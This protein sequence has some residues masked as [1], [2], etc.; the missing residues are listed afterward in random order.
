MIN[1]SQCRLCASLAL[2]GKHVPD[3]TS[4]LRH[5]WAACTTT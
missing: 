4:L 2:T 1:L 3:I 5:C